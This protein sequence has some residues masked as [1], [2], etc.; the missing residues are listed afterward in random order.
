MKLSAE[1]GQ[2]APID[3]G[4]LTALCDNK[5]VVSGVI[6][7]GFTVWNGTGH[8]VEHLAALNIDFRGK[9]VLDLGC[10]GGLLG[11][12]AIANGASHVAFQVIVA[13]SYC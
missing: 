9:R 12:Y 6:E 8:L 2:A 13:L 10:G 4:V 11:I 3:K 5:D 1:T 7:G